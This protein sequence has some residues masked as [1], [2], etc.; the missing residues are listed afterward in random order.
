MWIAQDDF[1]HPIVPAG[2]FDHLPSRIFQK[3]PTPSTHL[4]LRLPLLIS[5]ASI[6]F[7][8]AVSSYWFGRQSQSSTVVLEAVIPPKDMYDYLHDFTSFSSIELFAEVPNL[9]PEETQALMKDIKKP[10]A[11]VQPTEPGW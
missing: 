7:I 1:D 10:E 3:L 6:M 2:Y 4:W 11:S 8:A 5:A 9:T